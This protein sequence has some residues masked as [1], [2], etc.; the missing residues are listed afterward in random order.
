MNRQRHREI[1]DYYLETLRDHEILTQAQEQRL[2][3]RAQGDDPKAA[4]RA[5]EE[6]VRKNQ[7][8]IMKLAFRYKD[9]G[10]P[11]DDL[12]SEAN[13]GL[14]RAIEK[15]D[16]PD[17]KLST[18]A[19]WWVRNFLQRACMNQGRVVRVPIHAHERARKVRRVQAQMTQDLG[20]DATA[21]EVADA[22][23]LKQWFVEFA[24]SPDFNNVLSL[25]AERSDEFADGETY[26]SVIADEEDRGPELS[27][28]EAEGRDLILTALR[29]L[30][31]RQREML[32]RSVM[33]EES[34]ARAGREAGVSRQHAQRIRHDAC[35]RMADVLL[36]TECP[37]T[38]AH[39][40]S[41]GLKESYVLRVQQAYNALPEPDEPERTVAYF[42]NTS[43][44]A[45]YLKTKT[46]AAVVEH[47]AACSRGPRAPKR[48]YVL[49]RFPSGEL[50]KRGAL[51]V[52]GWLMPVMEEEDPP[53]ESGGASGAGAVVA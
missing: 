29:Q 50:V 17:L 48:V 4:A 23:G 52:R 3:R 28:E 6:L 10:L 2:L 14:L 39:L 49:R 12:I 30:K 34:M 43:G 8:L 13:I 31:P 45:S 9:L 26:V 7:R 25:D 33:Q 42:S 20:R 38:R 5:R 21:T 35:A 27:A 44:N 11:L 37:A 15:H 22:T 1:N 19:V 51:D 18:Y 41:L 32:W 40:N 46:K 47:E 36:E 53:P 24:L 16:D